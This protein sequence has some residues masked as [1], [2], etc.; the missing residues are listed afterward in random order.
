[1][2]L[3]NELV[4]ALHSLDVFVP[5]EHFFEIRPALTNLPDTTSLFVLDDNN[6]VTAIRRVMSEGKKAL[7]LETKP[8]LLI[9][10]ADLVQLRNLEWAF[11]QPLYRHDMRVVSLFDSSDVDVIREI[12]K[13]VGELHTPLDRLSDGGLTRSISHGKRKGYLLVGHVEGEAF[14]VRNASGTVTAQYTF[15]ELD[16]A[17]RASDSTVVFLGC[18]SA[19]VNGVT[20]FVDTVNA[21]KVAEGLANAINAATVIER[22]INRIILL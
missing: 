5:D 16:K 3:S 15:S 18:E 20:G 11:S 17:A 1:M 13:S 9:D 6:S 21:L 2:H 10:V 14:V 22:C 7:A 19:A 4:S 8:G 12:G